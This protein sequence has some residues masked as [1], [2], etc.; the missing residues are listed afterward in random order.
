LP[1]L[2][3]THFAKFKPGLGIPG[4]YAP[5][6]DGFINAMS[7]K[8]YGS[9][10][11]DPRLDLLLLHFHGWCKE[12]PCPIHPERAQRFE[13]PASCIFVKWVGN[14]EFNRTETVKML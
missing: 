10:N 9:R 14:H 1:D 12:G 8:L 13:G 5:A 4:Y 3:N 2:E 6:N 11:P 7:E